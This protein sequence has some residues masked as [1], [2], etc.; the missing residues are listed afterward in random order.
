MD[1]VPGLKGPYIK[2]VQGKI[3]FLEIITNIAW[4][5]IG[6]FKSLD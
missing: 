6:I 1:D 5:G 2:T 4:S 3:G